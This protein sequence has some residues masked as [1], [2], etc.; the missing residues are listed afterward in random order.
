MSRRYPLQPLLDATGLSMKGLRARCPMSGSTYRTAIDRGLTADQAD[1]WAV[2]CG[3]IPVAVWPELLDDAIDEV[4][5]QCASPDCSTTFVLDIGG[6][7]G[8]RRRYCGD[9]CKSRETVRAMRSRPGGTRRN[10][11][12]MRQYRA[13]E[14]A[15]REARRSRTETSTSSGSMSGPTT[16]GEAAA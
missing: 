11:E 15:A 13:H 8:T 5:R 9:T 16:N 2:R 10:V 14:R 12:Y 1:R 6:K 4:T 3:M 7:G